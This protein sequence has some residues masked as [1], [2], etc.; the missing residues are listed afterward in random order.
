MA[1]MDDLQQQTDSFLKAQAPEGT[2]ALGVEP[3]IVFRPDHLARATALADRLSALA[4][5]TPGPDGIAAVMAAVREAAQVENVD[6]VKYALMLFITHH[7]EARDL[8]IPPLEE[9]QPDVLPAEES[10][11]GTRALEEDG[12]RAIDP[13]ASL[14][15]YREDPGAN[16]HHEHW[17]V[18]YPG[19]GLGGRLKD[20]QGE[21]F[22]YMHQQ[23]IA[24]Y[25]TERLAMGLPR[26]APLSD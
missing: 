12:T 18:V 5:A 1:A 4:D 6:L 14:A 19:Q 2:R 13:E 24:R 9:R 20:R 16:E 3:F 11:A 23:M 21:L 15:W 22:V 25:D 10:E 26:V 7:P 17:H 8:T